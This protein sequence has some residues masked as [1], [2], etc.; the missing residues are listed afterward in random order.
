MFCYA[1]ADICSHMFIIFA[2]PILCF[3]IVH[4]LCPRSSSRLELVCQEIDRNVSQNWLLSVPVLRMR[5]RAVLPGMSCRE[6][7]PSARKPGC[8]LVLSSPGHTVHAESAR[9]ARVAWRVRWACGLRLRSADVN[10]ASFLFVRY[11][12]SHPLKY[13]VQHCSCA[14]NHSTTHTLLTLHSGVWLRHPS[15][16]IPT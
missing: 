1:L 7:E 10:A 15:S 12:L 9:A 3:C 14:K 11:H 4:P 6:P 5:V 13:A 16:R 8:Q 2:V